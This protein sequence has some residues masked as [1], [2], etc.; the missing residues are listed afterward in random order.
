MLK[1]CQP[2]MSH[3]RAFRNLWESFLKIEDGVFNAEQEK[4]IIHVRMEKE[5]VPRD[6]RL[7]SL[8]TPDAKQLFLVWIVLSPSHK[9][10]GFL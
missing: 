2:D 6:N 10:D 8:N 1:W 4:S 7:S 9:H 5:T 3:V